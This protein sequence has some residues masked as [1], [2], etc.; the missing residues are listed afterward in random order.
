MRS[1]TRA[2][3]GRAAISPNTA[4]PDAVR[5]HSMCVN[6]ARN[7][8]AARTCSPIARPAWSSGTD[9]SRSTIDTGLIHSCSR[10]CSGRGRYHITFSKRISPFAQTV[11]KVSS[12]P[13]TNSSTLTSGT[14]RS[15]GSTSASCAAESAR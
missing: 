12:S 11:S 1:T 14:C 15:I 2:P 7:P 13:S 8:S 5:Y 6:P 4:S 3:G 9:R 10:F